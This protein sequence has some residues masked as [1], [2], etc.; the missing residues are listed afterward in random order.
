MKHRTAEHVKPV[1]RPG[2]Q[3]AN[4]LFAGCRIRRISQRIQI[5]LDG[6]GGAILI[7]ARGI[8]TDNCDARHGVFFIPYVFFRIR[9]F[10]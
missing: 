4:D 2:Q 8:I 6:D 7:H 1:H 5:T 10:T 9:I 3:R